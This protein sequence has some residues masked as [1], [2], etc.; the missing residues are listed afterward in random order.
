[1]LSDFGWTRASV[2]G[3]FSLATIAQG[4]L[5]IFMG[6]L[7]DKIG[8]RVVL[9]VCGFSFGI[10]F[11]L[12]SEISS[13]WQLYLVYGLVVGAGVSGVWIPLMSTVARWFVARR[14][15]MSG[16]ALCGLSLG[17]ITVPLAATQL[18]SL[19]NWRTS[20][21]ILGSISLLIVVSVAQLLRRNPKI[22]EH[23]PD[24]NNKTD[25][26][27]LKLRGIGLKLSQAAR[28]KQFWLFIPMVFCSGYGLFALIIHVVPYT[29]ELGY[30]SSIA[31]GILAV[32][33]GV[34]IAGRV[35]LGVASDKIGNKRVFL[36]S[37]G[38]MASCFLWLY[39]SSDIWQLYIISIVFGFAYGGLS[40]AESPMVAELFGLSS[41]GLIYGVVN[42][43]WTTGASI[44]PLL[45]GYIFDLANSYEMAFL[46]AVAISLLGLLFTA[47]IRPVAAV[48]KIK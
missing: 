9:S 1:M 33:N 12:M 14:G 34:S 31:A 26:S 2:S 37:F 46:L 43:G 21:V 19:Y 18:M 7:N 22:I 42:I 5:A 35:I 28:T 17:G 25:A 20:Y 23:M 8:P 29:I 32:V 38:M 16:I 6:G 39:F 3:A 27:Q 40:V 44:G 45:T 48:K 13:V 4:L 41:H 11:L 30:S 24:S 36:L 10:G 47:S 15:L